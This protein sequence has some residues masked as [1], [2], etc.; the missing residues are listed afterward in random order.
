MNFFKR[1]FYRF[2]VDYLSAYSDNDIKYVKAQYY[3]KNERHLNLEEPEEFMEKIQWLKLFH[4]TGAYKDFADKYEVRKYVRDKVGD[5]IL[6]DIYGIYEYPEEIDLTE[7]PNSFV[8]KCTHASGTNIVVK[9]KRRLDWPKAAKRLKKWLAANYYKKSRERI[10][11]DIHPRII[12][13]KYLSELADG[14]LIDYK[15]YCFHG[16]PE[17]VLVK[18]NEGGTDKKCYYSMDWQKVLPENPGAGFLMTDIPKPSNFDE[19]REVAVKLSEGF[20]FMRVD[21][22]SVNGKTLFGEMTFFPTGGIKRLAVERLNKE[23]GDLIK[24]PAR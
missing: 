14:S 7:L 15:F 19:M 23:M 13:E 6:N 16:K 21:L 8:L 17:Y 1:K 5:H 10:Y 20:I 12:A 22:Y 9:D 11:K 2:Y 24:L 18:V 4:Y 3:L